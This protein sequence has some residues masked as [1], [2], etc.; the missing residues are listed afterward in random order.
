[1]LSERELHEPFSRCITEKYHTYW[2]QKTP[3]RLLFFLTAG[4]GGNPKG[5]GERSIAP[6]AAVALDLAAASITEA[7]ALSGAAATARNATAPAAA[8][9]TT[10]A[11]PGTRPIAGRRAAPAAE[12]RTTQ[13]PW[14]LA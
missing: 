8:A 3:N 6:G 4:R 7:A 14:T 11:A 10:G 13:Q 5:Y 12:A 2:I 1:M 9:R